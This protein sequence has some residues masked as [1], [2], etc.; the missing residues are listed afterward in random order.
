MGTM[1]RDIRPLSEDDL[2]ELSRFLTS[3]FH[4]PAEAEFAAPDVLRWKYLEPAHDD[5]PAERGAAAAPRSFVAR[6]K[7]ARIIGH[8]GLCRTAF[9]G[10]GIVT[11][12]GRVETAHIIDWLGSPDH[13][14]VGLSLMRRA[15]EGLPTLFGL[16]ATDL[17]HQVAERAGYE[18][19]RLVPAYTR[20]V[21]AGYW[22]RVAGLSP[23][24][25]LLRFAQELARRA[26]RPPAREARRLV[27]RRVSTFG[28]EIESIVARA[29]ERVIFTSRDPARLNQFLRFPGQSMS[30]WH[31]LDDENRLRGFAILN[32]IRHDGGRT[33]VGKIVDCLLDEVEVPV[34]AAALESLSR[35]LGRQGADLALAYASTPWTVDALRQCGFTTRYGVKFHIRDRQGLIPR[36]ATFHLTPLEGDFAY[37]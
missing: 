31:L 34:W 24:K 10:W 1:T 36:A 28:P 22:F 11:P 12:G 3:G 16:G 5:S 20:T 33:S 30:G 21:R 13:R 35:E 6:D 2:P 7:A 8:L 4:A 15:H 29:Q 37:T 14:A 27:L 26:V 17:A 18:L 9:A 19:I 23:H 25:R 32:L